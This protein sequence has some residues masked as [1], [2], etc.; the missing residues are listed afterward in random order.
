MSAK[1]AKENSA[2]V[3]RL[4]K[5]NMSLFSDYCGLYQLCERLLKSYKEHENME[6]L[7]KALEKELAVHFPCPF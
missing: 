5:R 6:E 2:E 3:E 1:K 7:Y 4:E